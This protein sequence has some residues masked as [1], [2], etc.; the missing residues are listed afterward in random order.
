MRELRRPSIY[1]SNLAALIISCL[2]NQAFACVPDRPPPCIANQSEK[3]CRERAEQ[4]YADQEAAR[5][6]YEKKTPQERALIEQAQLWEDHEII[7]L[8]RVEKVKLDGKIYP[9]PRPKLA[10]ARKGKL[11]PPPAPVLIPPMFTGRGHDSFIRPIGQ[12]KG[13]PTFAASWQYVGG[14]TSCGNTPDGS[15]GYAYP[16]DEVI[17]FASPASRSR[18]VRGK[19]ESEEYLSLFGLSR[20]ELV[21]PRI[22]A[23]L[24][25]GVP[26]KA[27]PKQ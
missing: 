3:D 8:A 27:E 19:W 14:I 6:A 10:K 4:W 23:A 17:I 2:S 22:L 18:Q 16:G 26:S 1:F 25:G 24:S 21:E 11:P 9:Q 7:F 13:P 5:V 20:A 15:L 12:I